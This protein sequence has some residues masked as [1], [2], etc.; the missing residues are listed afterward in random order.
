MV[1]LHFIQQLILRVPSSLVRIGRDEYGEAAKKFSSFLH[2]LATKPRRGGAF[3]RVS[4]IRPLFVLWT[5]PTTGIAIC[6][7]ATWFYEPPMSP[8]GYKQKSGP[9]RRYVCFASNSRHSSVNVRYAIGTAA[10]A[11]R[12]Q[13]TAIPALARL[14]EALASRGHQG[15]GRAGHHAALTSQR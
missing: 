8:L 12:S 6:Q 1:N 9:C 2:I 13:P 4:S 15:A 11:G 5:A 14:L 7:R 10:S 3:L